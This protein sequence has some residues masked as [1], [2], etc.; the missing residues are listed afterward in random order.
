MSTQNKDSLA[1]LHYDILITLLRT[2]LRSKTIAKALPS[3]EL[4]ARQ[5]AN[6]LKQLAKRGFTIYIPSP[7]G[8]YWC[9]TSRG[10]SVAETIKLKRATKW[11]LRTIGRGHYSG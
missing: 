10:R 6:H 3:H 4:N 9:L 1:D 8:A 5:V 2:G 11:D 7:A